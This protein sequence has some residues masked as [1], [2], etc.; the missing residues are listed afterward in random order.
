[1]LYGVGLVEIYYLPR[2]GAAVFLGAMG[3]TFFGA[4]LLMHK[5]RI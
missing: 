4:L 5:N 2:Y 3:I 1:M